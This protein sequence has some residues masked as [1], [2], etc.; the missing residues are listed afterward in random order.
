MYEMNVDTNEQY[1]HERMRRPHKYIG[2]TMYVG[3]SN[4]TITFG[5]PICRDA[6]FANNENIFNV[7]EQVATRRRI[8]ITRV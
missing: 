1:F 7:Y 2:G 8:S 3:M 4:L 5:L 6:Y